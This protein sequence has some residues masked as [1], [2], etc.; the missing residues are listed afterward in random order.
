M[1]TPAINL[2]LLSDPSAVEALRSVFSMHEA[3]L[4]RADV[5]ASRMA[6]LGWQATSESDRLLRSDRFTFSALC[7]ALKRGHANLP[8]S[9]GQPS[10]LAMHLARSEGE[11]QPSDA[12]GARGRLRR[13]LIDTGATFL[14][15]PLVSA[16]AAIDGTAVTE[17][18]VTR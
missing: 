11:E 8:S 16:E 1:S 9:F 15:R 14:M 17:R 12:P 2:S 4:L 5:F 7:V 6:D 18:S 13:D 10:I 3:G